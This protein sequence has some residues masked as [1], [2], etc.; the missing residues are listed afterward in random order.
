MAKV[1]YFFFP[2]KV[3]FCALFEEYQMNEWKSCFFFRIVF[4]FPASKIEWMNDM[5]TFPGKKHTHTKMNKNAVK[6]HNTCFL[7]KEELLKIRLSDRWTFPWEKNTSCF[8][9]DQNY[10]IGEKQTRSSDLNE[11]TAYEL[12]RGENNTVPLITPFFILD[13]IFVLSDF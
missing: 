11:W 3:R 8:F 4:F 2:G 7:K 10:V 1:S 12:I 6:T 5:W 9:S 13:H